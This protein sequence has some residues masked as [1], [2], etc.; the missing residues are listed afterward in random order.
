[1]NNLRY[2]LSYIILYL[3]SCYIII[4]LNINILIVF[5]QHTINKLNYIILTECGTKRRQSKY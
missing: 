5:L 3:C 4:I 2:L 1:M